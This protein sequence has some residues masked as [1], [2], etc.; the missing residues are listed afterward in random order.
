MKK[1]LIT[2]FVIAAFSALLTLSVCAEGGRAPG[3][4][5]TNQQELF[6]ALG[7][8]ENCLLNSDGVL[9]CF[10]A[11]L[12]NPIVLDGG[13]YTL[14]GAGAKL[15]SLENGCVF[16]LRNGASL[17][18]GN[19][20]GSS[21]DGIIFEGTGTAR[22]L[23]I[24]DGC[25][26]NVLFGVSASG[27]SRV[28]TN[29]GAFALYAGTFENCGDADCDGGF[30]LNYGT[31]L[32]AGGT[33]RNCFAAI[34]GA[35]YNHEGGTLSLAGTEIGDCHADTGGAVMNAGEAE[36]VSSYVSGCYA[37]DGGAV[38]N[39]GTFAFSGGQIS[40]SVAH[41]DGGAVYN[42]ETG[43]I[44]F[45]GTFIDGSTA[46]GNGGTVFCAGKGSLTEGTLSGGTA[47]KG[48]N[49]YVTGE[50]ELTGGSVSHGTAALGGGA[51]NCGTV[52]VKGGGFS[53]CT[54]DFGSALFNT[55]RLVF[56]EYPY[57]DKKY[58]VF[59]D[60]NNHDGIPE[61]AS[62][63]K[64]ETICFI[65]PGRYSGDTASTDYTPGTLLL[66]GEY[67]AQC[68]GHFAVSPQG[69]REWKIE[70][71]RLAAVKTMWERPWIYI[72]TV[73]LWAAFVAVTS[74]L[75]IRFSGK[76]HEKGK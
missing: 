23:E 57:I 43:E 45:S 34:G 56:S 40:G 1:G 16:E 76:K 72:G 6:E 71:G 47:K 20:T 60:L 24:G 15:A 21:T 35:V 46:D 41:G 62:E 39:S 66:Q 2:V 8:E 51:F 69:G 13:E 32:L 5:V 19:L 42:S 18:L 14:T 48:G 70:D 36:I 17:T 52:Y 55:G 74:L 28:V 54:A 22:L 27:F 50:F 63:M 64:A 29:S 58:D 65:T 49:L 75:G 73:L 11:A 59:V 12:E 3:G 31:A 53:V 7:G 67:A 33:V 9:L 30:L 4:T 10:D 26:A 61:I 25:T 38:Y 44:R 68:S 37:T